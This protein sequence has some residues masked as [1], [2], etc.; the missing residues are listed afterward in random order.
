VALQAIDAP[1][2]LIAGGRDKKLPWEEFARLVGQRVRGLFLIGEAAPQIEAAVRNA[3][4]GLAGVLSETMIQR[5]ESLQEAVRL[6]S[7]E[8]RPGEAVLL[9]PACTSYDMFS[10]FEERG[11]VFARSVEALNAA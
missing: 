2:L 6:A 4:P 1:I 11:R 9:S 8:A 3:L 10:D 5:C 7:A